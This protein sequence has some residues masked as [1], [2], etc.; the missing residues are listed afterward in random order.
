MAD[1]LGLVQSLIDGTREVFGWWTDEAG[2]IEASKRKALR[3]KRE[4]C[5]R[6]LIDNRFTDLARLTDELR[7]LSEEA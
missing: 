5:Q 7:R 6:A 2:R 1:P 3:K 4:E